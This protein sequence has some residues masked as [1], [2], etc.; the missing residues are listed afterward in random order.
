MKGGTNPRFDNCRSKNN[1]CCNKCCIKEK[2]NPCHDGYDHHDDQDNYYD[3][4]CSRYDAD[5]P[6]KENKDNYFHNFC[7]RYGDDFPRKN[8]IDLHMSCEC[9]CV[10][11]KD[12]CIRTNT[13]CKA[14][15][16]ICPIFKNNRDKC[17][18]ESC[19]DAIY[20]VKPNNPNSNFRDKKGINDCSNIL[21]KY[22][23]DLGHPNTY[24]FPQFVSSTKSNFTLLGDTRDIVGVSFTNG[25]QADTGVRFPEPLIT[26]NVGTGSKLDISFT[27]NSIKIAY[28]NGS[29]FPFPSTLTQPNFGAL[30]AGDRIRIWDP[31][32]TL[33]TN[34]TVSSAIGNKINFS[35]VYAHPINIPLGYTVTILPN[36]IIELNGFSRF[37][38][39]G[40][41]QINGILFVD[42][43]IPNTALQLQARLLYINNNVFDDTLY[44]TAKKT[45]NF[46]PN[47]FYGKV[48]INAATHPFLAF[49]S[50]IGPKSTL[51]VESNA[52]GWIIFST[53]AGSDDSNEQS[54]GTPHAGYIGVNGSQFCI[55][56]SSFLACPTTA[57]DISSAEVNVQHVLIDGTINSGKGNGIIQQYGS[58]IYTA[59]LPDLN[60]SGTALTINNTIVGLTIYYG[61][62]AYVPLINM[63]GTDTDIIIDGLS[64]GLISA[65]PNFKPVVVNAQ[66]TAPIL[67]LVPLIIPPFGSII[68]HTP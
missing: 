34:L 60:N 2:N 11:D 47:T 4:L 52:Y 10:E 42:N 48:I 9:G 28:L 35:T 43:N 51:W 26:P 66:G 24:H 63:N 5:V 30:V 18:D 40:D 27:N 7:S 1:I 31:T 49:V 3:S 25:A 20:K 44:N 50:F 67:P 38:I 59:P 14:S 15:N 8:S 19:F 61:S 36:V 45:M 55:A 23:S 39:V 62:H 41:L 46:Q 29:T 22:R 13:K 68:Y 6:H 53:W 37:I 56:W 54:D 32:T 16:N 64:Y 21:I 65:A 33:F 12:R 58:K 17:I 57:I